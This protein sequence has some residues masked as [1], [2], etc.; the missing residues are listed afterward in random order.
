M[1]SVRGRSSATGAVVDR[2]IATL[3]NPHTT[4]RIKVIQYSLVVAIAPAASAGFKL[5]RIST[6]GTPGTT[7]IPGLPNHSQGAIAPPSGALLDLGAYGVEPTVVGAELGPGWPLAAVAASGFIYP[8][9]SSGIE[10]A[11]GTGLALCNIGAVITP[12]ADISFAWLED[13]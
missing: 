13:W 2:V 8:I 5:K 10:I 1:Y 4:Q 9:P 7:E 3:W 11:P 6:R 12:A